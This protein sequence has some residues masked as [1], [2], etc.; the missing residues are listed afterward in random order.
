MK[1]VLTAEA[2]A[3]LDAA[4]I[5]ELE[6]L[7]DR[8]GYSVAVNAIEMGFGY[9]KRVS[10]LVGPG[11]NGG[12]GYIAAAYLKRRGAAVTVFHLAEPKS[13]LAKDAAL[14]AHYTG[15]PILAWVDAPVDSDL[16]IDA[17]FGGGFRGTLP[18][19]ILSWSSTGWPV[20]S[21]DVPSGV[22]ASTGEAGKGAFHATRTV[23]FHSSKVGH[24]LGEGAACTG[25]LV[26]ADIGLSGGEAAFSIVETSDAPRPPRLPH[27]HK[28]SSGSVAVVGGSRGMGGAAL[29]AARS[30]LASGAGAVMV[31]ATA[32]LI[33][34]YRAA[35]EL[36]TAVRGDGMAGADEFLEQAERFDALV[37]GPGLGPGN[38]EFVG[39]VLSSAIQPVI[40]DAGGLASTTVDSL[41]SRS[42]PTVLTPH[43]AEFERLF[44]TGASYQAAAALAQRTGAV[45]LL[46]GGPTFVVGDNGVACVT[47]PGPELATI[48]TGDVLAGA[49]A[50]FISRGLV[51]AAA[52]ASAAFWHGQAGAALS[53]AGTVT[54]DRLVDELRKWVW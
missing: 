25:E 17:L 19:E 30:A 45:V 20:L 3:A 4:H 24:W 35:P 5:D 9:G 18:A 43:A 52:A 54:A 49:V 41:A 40:L 42:G 37:V 6:V 27:A 50:A 51:P 10:V 21:V 12:D 48:G 46:K 47:T 44:A 36:L 15:V 38:D 7:M 31:S 1:R 53:T 34:T 2:S 39:R 28:W 13:Q 23:T 33:D 14:R 32:D 22:N 29:L 8:A 26:V 16:I 11:N